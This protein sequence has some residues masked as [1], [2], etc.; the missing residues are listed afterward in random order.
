[1]PTYRAALFDFFGTLTHAV[2]R[3]PMHGSI[4][5]ALGVDAETMTA[6]LDWSFVDRSRGTFGDAA[7]TLRWICAQASGR[8]GPDQLRRALADRV[9]AVRADT[10]LRPDAVS[11]LR[12][13]RGSGVRTA[14]VS[15]CGHELP[16]FLPRLPISPLLDARVY[17]VHVGQR[18]PHPSMYLTACRRLGVQPR[19]CLYVGDGGSRELSGAADLGMTAVRLA[20]PDLADHLVYDAETWTG[21]TIRSLSEVVGLVAQAPEAVQALR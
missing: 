13:L 15:D 18:K 10:D 17:S 14:V 1:M 21:P 19:E 8:P 11:S 3:G 6:V 12:A 4:A 7:Q 5:R 20:A 2:R 16:A 9:A